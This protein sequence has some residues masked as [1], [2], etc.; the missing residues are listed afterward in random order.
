MYKNIYKSGKGKNLITQQFIQNAMFTTFLASFWCCSMYEF[1]KT[2]SL[3]KN[4]ME[5]TL[6][7]FCFRLHN[8]PRRKFPK[9][10]KMYAL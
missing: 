3:F 10:F 5:N 2:L 7:Q 8:I 6:Q 9:H 1:Y 4:F